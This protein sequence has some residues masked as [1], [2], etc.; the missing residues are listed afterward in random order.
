[1]IINGKECE[2]T[3]EANILEVIRKNGFN[4]PL[5]TNQVVVNFKSILKNME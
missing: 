5:V 3:N 1:M 2:F 4:V